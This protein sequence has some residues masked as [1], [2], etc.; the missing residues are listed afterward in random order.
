MAEQHNLHVVRHA[1]DAFSRG[2][3][4]TVIAQLS[5][6]VVWDLPGPSHIPYA[7]IFHGKDGVLEF[8]RRLA[9]SDVTHTFEP[10]RFFADR[11][12]VVVVGRYAA[13]VKA[14]GRLAETQ[15]VHTFTFREGKVAQWHEYFDTAKYAQ[16]Y[17]PAAVPTG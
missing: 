12:M 8:F 14:T 7:G 4:D 11:D 9:E 16:A 5:D 6:D 2:D 10:Q 1:Y 3:I 13:R 17:E 15:W